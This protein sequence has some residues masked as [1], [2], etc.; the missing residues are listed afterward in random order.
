MPG[1]V[2]DGR[3]LHIAWPADSAMPTARW[4]MRS[5]LP[6]LHVAAGRRHIRLIAGRYRNI[7]A[8][9]LWWLVCSL[10]GHRPGVGR[11]PLYDLASLS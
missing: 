2:E 4:A 11:R 10:D 6:N 8:G 5:V 3:E 7:L 1:D 9:D